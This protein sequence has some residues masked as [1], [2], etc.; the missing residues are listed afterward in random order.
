MFAKLNETFR[1]PPSKSDTS[2]PESCT[3]YFLLRPTPEIIAHQTNLMLLRSSNLHNQHPYTVR[4]RAL[5]IESAITQKLA[6]P[7]CLDTSPE[8]LITANFNQFQRFKYNHPRLKLLRRKFAKFNAKPKLSIKQ[9]ASTDLRLLDYLANTTSI[10]GC[11]KSQN[12]SLV[13]TSMKEC[14]LLKSSSNLLNNIA[15]S[16]PER[17]METAIRSKLQRRNSA[18]YSDQV[19]NPQHYHI[20][21]SHSNS[22]PN[23]SYRSDLQSPMRKASYPTHYSPMYPEAISQF[24][25]L[26]ASTPGTPPVEPFTPIEEPRYPQTNP[27]ET[28]QLLDYTTPTNS[29]GMLRRNSFHTPS[30]MTSSDMHLRG[31]QQASMECTTNSVMNDVY[32]SR[33][34]SHVCEQDKQH[35]P[36]QMQGLPKFPNAFSNKAQSQNQFITNTNKFP[37]KY[38]PGQQQPSY[39]G[40]AGLPSLPPYQPNTRIPHNIITSNPSQF[41]MESSLKHLVGNKRHLDSINHITTQAKRYTASPG[42]NLPIPINQTT[43]MQ[44]P[45]DIRHTNH[46]IRGAQPVNGPNFVSGRKIPQ[47]IYP[48]YSNQLP[49]HD[50]PVFNHTSIQNSN[51]HHTNP[52]TPVE[53]SEH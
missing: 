51:F 20:A 3:H 18:S 25:S 40:G 53:Q 31:N 44:Y 48:P 9:C 22:L 6:P 46:M 47:N 49:T 43:N 26:S 27:L 10:L 45:K 19:A 42:P 5:Q 36:A 15:I 37:Q 33:H 52:H 29:I 2:H 41:P 21:K 23:S 11:K 30:S 13:G 24:R 35:L 4:H 32:T 38:Y 1:A 28:S 17:A 8:V 34:N 7:L 14:M 50:Y 16:R 39:P 12:F